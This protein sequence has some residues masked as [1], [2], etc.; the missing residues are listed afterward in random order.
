MANFKT[1]FI[2]VLSWQAPCKAQIFDS[3]LS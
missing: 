2:I 1:A 3:V